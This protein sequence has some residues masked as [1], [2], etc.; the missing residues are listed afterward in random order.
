MKLNL[1]KQK[2]DVIIVGTGAGGATA[3]KELSHKKKKVMMLEWG[4]N[5]PLTGSFA[6]ARKRAS[7]NVMMIIQ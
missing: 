1:T 3:A 4:D 2:I 7:R 5:S 6:K